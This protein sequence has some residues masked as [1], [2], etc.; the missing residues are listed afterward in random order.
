MAARHRGLYLLHY[1]IE[2]SASLASRLGHAAP[3]GNERTAMHK[4]SLIVLT[5]MVV[6]FSLLDYVGCKKSPPPLTTGG[7]DAT[8][9]AQPPVIDEKTQSII[10]ELAKRWEEWPAFSADVATVLPT[11]AG[12]PGVTKGKGTYVWTKRGDK[13]L[14]RFFLSNWLKFDLGDTKTAITSEV[15]IFLYDGEFLYSQLQQPIEFKET[16]KSR[17]QPERILQIGGQDLFKTLAETNELKLVG[18]EMLDVRAAYVIEA[19]PVTGNGSSVH[20]FDKQTGARLKM[21]ERDES[22]KAVLTLSLSNLNTNPELSEDR[23]IYT[24]PEGFK[25]I[26]R[27]QD[28]P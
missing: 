8:S 10:A 2:V 6:A 23:F 20:Y 19:R 28:S 12:K 24:L 22:G 1:S 25:L 4:Q 18:E 16:T 27:T 14:I 3:V 7:G 15:L 21:I 5:G 13:R 11:A 9:R 17:Y 26:D